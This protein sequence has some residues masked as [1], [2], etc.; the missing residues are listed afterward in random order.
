MQKGKN[1]NTPIAFLLSVAL[2][3][4]ATPNDLRQKAPDLQLNS[5]KSAKDVAICITDKWEASPVGSA[6]VTMRETKTGY[7]VLMLCNTNACLM[8]D[9]FS[10]ENG[11]RTC[12]YNNAILADG[13]VKDV[14]DCQ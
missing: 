4:C 2:V 12:F 1:I 3:G 7:T 13:Y 14:K 11:S 6:P 5:A 9:I 10:N 8:S